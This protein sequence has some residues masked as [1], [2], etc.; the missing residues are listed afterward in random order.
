MTAEDRD[1]VEKYYIYISGTS[2]FLELLK[3]ELSEIG[4]L[5]IREISDNEIYED[6]KN[7]ISI[8]LVYGNEIT[9]KIFHLFD[10]C[11]ALI[12]LYDFITGAGA[13]VLFPGSFPDLIPNEL[14]RHALAKYISGYCAF[15]NMENNNLSTE[16]LK[17]I[18]SD[19]RNNN[20]MKLAAE[21][22]AKIAANIATCRK[23]KSYPRFYLVKC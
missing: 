11:H 12:F 4:F 16:T 13:V 5:D 3:Q 1:A 17:E 6:D 18:C 20:S 9:T 14:S 22:G 8:E 23:V 15:W 19:K 10:N 2:E 7:S 21:L